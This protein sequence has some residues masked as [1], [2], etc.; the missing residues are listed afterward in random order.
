MLK[1]LL[2]DDIISKARFS[3]EVLSIRGAL[4]LLFVVFSQHRL[5]CINFFAS[6]IMAVMDSRSEKQA[7]NL[8]QDLESC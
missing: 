5:N 6:H 1:R 8:K 2:S 3:S 7:V 4:C